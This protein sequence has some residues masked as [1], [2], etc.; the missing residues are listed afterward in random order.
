VLE[1]PSPRSSGW[2]HHYARLCVQHF[3]K[4]TDE[5]R[6]TTDREDF[7]RFLKAATGAGTSGYMVQHTLTML[8]RILIHTGKR[9][10]ELTS[11][12]L[13]EYSKTVK[14][15]D[16][17]VTGTQT[18]HQLLSDLGI[19]ENGPFTGRPRMGQVSI[20]DMVDSYGPACREVR[21]VFVTYLREQATSL[22]YGS[23]RMLE[24]H[25]VELFWCDLEQH[26][27]GIHSLNLTPEMASAWKKRVRTK[28]DGQPRLTLE[29]LFISVRAFYLDV[30]QWALE[31][32][33]CGE[34]TRFRRRYPKPTRD[35]C[36][37]RRISGAPG[38]THAS[39]L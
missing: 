11:P 30:A 23:I 20:E 38:S 26:H 14:R 35:L 22:D 3:N 21:D 17:K 25:L 1:Y 29:H 31:R 24:L 13:L 28:P 9:M 12:D 8:A 27:P 32:P 39:A 6:T 37:K 16:R 7:E 15:L 19:I 5:L 33:T 34:P 10:P 18:A 2:S 4:L 36:A